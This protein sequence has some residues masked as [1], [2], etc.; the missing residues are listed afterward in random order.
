[1]WIGHKVMY[2]DYVRLVFGGRSISIQR[3]VNEK[4]QAILKK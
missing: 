2:Y 1:M 4:V 3:I